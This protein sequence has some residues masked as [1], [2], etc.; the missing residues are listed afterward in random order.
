M[1]SQHKELKTKEENSKLITTL[2]RKEK[3]VSQ[4]PTNK[5]GLGVKNMNI[6]DQAIITNEGWEATLNLRVLVQ[7]DMNK[8]M[9]NV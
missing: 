4:L 8:E 7:Q 9:F 2:N 1:K 3:P 6:Q 5:T